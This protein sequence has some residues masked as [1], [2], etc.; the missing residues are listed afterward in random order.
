MYESRKS[1]TVGAE[2]HDR[3]A[4]RFVFAS[5]GAVLGKS[6][7]L[8]E[9]V[10]QAMVSRGYRGDAKVMTQPK[11][12]W[13]DFVFAFAGAAFAACLLVGEHLLVR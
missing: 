8:S 6:L 7:A 4:R 2:K 12:V 3:A 10:H 9:E 1:R 13:R 11:P 5:A